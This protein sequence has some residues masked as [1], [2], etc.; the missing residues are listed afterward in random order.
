LQSPKTLSADNVRDEAAEN[1]GQR[2]GDD[3]SNCRDGVHC[4]TPDG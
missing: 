1:N 4:L 3:K 2:Y